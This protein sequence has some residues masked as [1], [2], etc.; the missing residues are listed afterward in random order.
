M[1]LVGLTGGIATGKS[2]FAAALRARGAAVIDADALARAAVA[3]GSPAL[4]EIAAAFGAE[5]LAP[6]G[7]LDRA[8]MASRVFAD[9]AARARLEAIVHPRVRALFR[10]ERDRLAADGRALAFYDVPL[11]YEARLEGEVELVVVV[12]AP[13]EA[14]IARL[15]SRDSLD[16]PAAEARLAAQLPV[17][18]KAARADAVV[19][20]DGDPAALAAKAER[21]LADLGAGLGRKLPNRPPARY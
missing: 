13:R 19:V 15:A 9:P 1:R 16:R 12:W 3:K 2:T 4:A 20:N 21:L 7:A 10:A 18:E 6:D 5:V 11:L 14:Q 17:D 8:R